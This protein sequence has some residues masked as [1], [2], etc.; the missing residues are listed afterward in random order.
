MIGCEGLSAGDTAYLASHRGVF[1]PFSDAWNNMLAF[2]TGGEGT[3]AKDDLK[4]DPKAGTYTVPG[5]HSGGP[6]RIR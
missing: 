5:Y 6:V 1:S 3:R 4:V 2:L